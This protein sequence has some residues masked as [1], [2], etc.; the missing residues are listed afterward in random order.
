M[1]NLQKYAANILKKIRNSLTT[2]I[3]KYYSTYIGLACSQINSLPMKG[4][5]EAGD[6][7]CIKTQTEEIKPVSS[8]DRVIF[9][10][11]LLSLVC[12][13]TSRRL[14]CD[15]RSLCVSYSCVSGGPKLFLSQCCTQR[16]GSPRQ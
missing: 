4:A 12:N 6:I 15:F 14:I 1:N 16:V 2:L 9:T 11:F 7:S 3:N 8:D 13:G 10:F 5:G